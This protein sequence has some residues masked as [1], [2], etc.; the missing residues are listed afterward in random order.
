[1]WWLFYKQHGCH[2]N[3]VPANHQGIDDDYGGGAGREIVMVIWMAP[4]T[5]SGIVALVY[6]IALYVCVCVGMC[7][8]NIDISNACYQIIDMNIY[9]DY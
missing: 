1:M 9:I 8:N 6:I 3:P 4:G 2:H 5:T 7:Q